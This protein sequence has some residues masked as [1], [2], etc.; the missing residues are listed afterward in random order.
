MG[1]QVPRSNLI[2]WAI[3]A[4]LAVAPTAWADAPAKPTFEDK[5]LP[6]LKERCFKCHAGAEP[7][8]GL[9]LTSRREI[10]AGGKSGAAIR[11]NAAESSLLWIKIAGNDMPKGGPPLTAEEKGILR[12]WI[13]DGAPSSE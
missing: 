1:S 7:K 11:I 4:L 10:L 5:V 2:G 6:I 9:K 12:T 8:N 3:G 13:N